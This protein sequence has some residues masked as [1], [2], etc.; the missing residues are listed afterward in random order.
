MRRL[1]LSLSCVS[2]VLGSN[3]GC[4]KTGI[5]PLFHPGPAEY[6]RQDEAYWDP[7]TKNVMNDVSLDGTRPRDFDR[8]TSEVKN[9]QTTP[10]D[11]GARAASDF[12]PLRDAAE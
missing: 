6:Q 3:T 2:L 7:Y 10:H 4:R 8:P 11:A 1:I 12:V 9:A 5:R